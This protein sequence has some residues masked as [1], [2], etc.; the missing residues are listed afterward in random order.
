MKALWV[1]GLVLLSAPAGAAG[2]YEFDR[3]QWEQKQPQTAAEKDQ[4]TPPTP[5]PQAR[6]PATTPPSSAPAPAAGDMAQTTDCPTGQ[7][8]NDL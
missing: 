1:A 2:I 4:K 5:P 7:T 6:Q 8:C 3:S